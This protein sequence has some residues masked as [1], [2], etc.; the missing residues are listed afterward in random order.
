MHLGGGKERQQTIGNSFK[1]TLRD[2]DFIL[3]HFHLA[4][5]WNNLDNLKWVP[6]SPPLLSSTHPPA[7]LSFS[8]SISSRYVEILEGTVHTWSQLIDRIN[9][10]K[11][12]FPSNSKRTAPFLTVPHSP[13]LRSNTNVGLPF[14]LSIRSSYKKKNGE[15]FEFQSDDWA[16]AEKNGQINSKRALSECSISSN[17]HLAL[18]GLTPLCAPRSWL[19]QTRVSSKDQSTRETNIYHFSI[20]LYYMKLWLCVYKEP[21]SG[22][23]CLISIRMTRV[24][25]G[26]GRT[27]RLVRLRHFF[28]KPTK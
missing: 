5:N 28:Q 7:A 6:I 21:E 3:R 14:E 11:I 4:A 19:Y 24:D 9:N 26:R 17:I 20:N 18:F 16:K 8:L 22:A 1:T 27:Q 2:A 15:E 25:N 23:A 10:V 13:S 12:I